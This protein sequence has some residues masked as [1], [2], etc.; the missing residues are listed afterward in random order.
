MEPGLGIDGE[1]QVPDA[2]FGKDLPAAGKSRQK[3]YLPSGIQGD[4]FT[5]GRPDAVSPSHRHH[6]SGLN[7][8][9]PVPPDKPLPEHHEAGTGFIKMQSQADPTVIQHL[10]I[11]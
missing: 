4:G 1:G 10:V 11:V 9:S 8:S 3:G 2:V 5:L 6:G 7:P